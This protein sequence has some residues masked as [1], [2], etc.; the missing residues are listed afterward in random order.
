MRRVAR[1]RYGYSYYSNIL[2][3]DIEFALSKILERELHLVK[4]IDNILTDLRLQPDF[5]AAEIFN[6]LD[7]SKLNY[8]NSDG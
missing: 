5:N 4:N 2:P 6:S 7:L 3:Y 1:E 8:V